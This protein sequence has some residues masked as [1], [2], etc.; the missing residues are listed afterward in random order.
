MGHNLI[1]DFYYSLFPSIN[2]YL[3]SKRGKSN[4]ILSAPHGGGIKPTSIPNRT[5]GNRSGDSHT[6][7]LIQKVIENLHEQ[8]YY[9][10]A[11][12]H[13][14]KVDLNRGFE[15]ASQGNLEMQ[16]IWNAWNRTLDSYTGEIRYYDKRGLY[17]DI[18]SHKKSEN[19]ELGYG[20][21]VIDYRK[22]LHE[23]TPEKH[24]TLFSLAGKISERELLF[25]E[26]SFETR[27]K[28]FGY[29][30]LNPKSDDTYLNGGRNINIFHGNG[31]GAIQIE[32]PIPVL[33]RDLNG[34]AMAIADA[35][36]NFKYNYLD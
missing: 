3:Q 14:S 11:D 22:I 8:P 13:R 28:D 35:I 19:F 20:L 9:I 12:I 34:V 16:A 30:V 27:L 15:E 2:K 7:R 1:R 32:C 21:S 33:K 29:S 26:F 31:I 24:S 5:Y 10:Y 18:H 6:R 36:E 4:I 23:N 25:G 17:V